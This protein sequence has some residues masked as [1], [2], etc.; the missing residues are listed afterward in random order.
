VSIDEVP[1]AL[2]RPCCPGG[3]AVANHVA[4]A[5]SL[6]PI[7]SSCATSSTVHADMVRLLQRCEMAWCDDLHSL[8]T[9][10]R[11]FIQTV[12][13][14]NFLTRPQLGQVVLPGARASLLTAASAAAADMMELLATLAI[15]P[16][17]VPYFDGELQRATDVAVTAT[18]AV[19]LSLPVDGLCAAM[20]GQDTVVQ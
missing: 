15:Q 3:G 7:R 10:V 5:T 18:A 16:A 20:V 6:P 12:P 11:N 13:N 1:S 17:R 14:P 9:N 8:Q 19:D 4:R 2:G